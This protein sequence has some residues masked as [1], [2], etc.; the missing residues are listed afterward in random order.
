MLLQALTLII[1]HDYVIS[2][3]TEY[4]KQC[5]H[6]L[7]HRS[8]LYS[9]DLF[10]GQ[11]LW[12]FSEQSVSVGKWNWSMQFGSSFYMVHTTTAA[13]SNNLKRPVT[14]DRTIIGSHDLW[15]NRL[16]QGQSPLSSTF[17]HCVCTYATVLRL[18]VRLV[19]RLVVRSRLTYDCVRSIVRS[20]V[21][22]HDWSHDYRCDKSKP[23]MR[24]VGRQY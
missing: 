7:S 5:T 4:L 19:A 15:E 17:C 11:Y 2:Y 8:T 10:V 22:G 18:V 14:L 12:L 9:T 6:F 16:T 24:L 3:Y 20:I 13:C 23:V 21:V 1:C